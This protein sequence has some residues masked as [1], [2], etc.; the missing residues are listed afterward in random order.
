MKNKV[1]DN[2]HFMLFH[3]RSGYRRSSKKLQ[4]LEGDA[5]IKALGYKSSEV[6]Y[7]TSEGPLYIS[8]KTSKT[9]IETTLL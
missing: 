6:S 4:K 2:I 9:S 8:I 3:R 7:M 5:L 1:N